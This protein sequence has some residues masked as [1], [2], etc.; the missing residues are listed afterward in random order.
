VDII[1][2]IAFAGGLGIGMLIQFFEGQR[3]SNTKVCTPSA[4]HNSNYTAAIAVFREY[5]SY[6]PMTA[7][8][9]GFEKYCNDCLNAAKSRHCV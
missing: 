4:S 2:C 7:S 8:M 9:R 1:V 6:A 5:S 3:N